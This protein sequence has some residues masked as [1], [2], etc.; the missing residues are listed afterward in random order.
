MAFAQIGPLTRLLETGAA[1]VGAG[2]L[3]GGFAAGA[4]G[5][6]MGWPRREFDRWV[7]LSSYGGG[8]LAM[9]LVIV[10]ITFRY[11]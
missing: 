4:V 3:L 7:L 2:M 1:A 5:L 8:V 9:G 10:D 11:A 6:A